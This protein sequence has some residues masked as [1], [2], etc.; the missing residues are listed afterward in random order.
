MCLCL[1]V[2]LSLLLSCRNSSLA[3]SILLQSLG[4]RLGVENAQLVPPTRVIEANMSS[5]IYFLRSRVQGHWSITP[6]NPSVILL[7]NL[8]C[9]M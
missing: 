4:G 9:A 5:I 1:L 8:D 2:F 7:S 3:R 6:D